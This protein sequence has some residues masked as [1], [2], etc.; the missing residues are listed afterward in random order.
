MHISIE[1]ETQNVIHRTWSPLYAKEE[2]RKNCLPQSSLFQEEYSWRRFHRSYRMKAVSKRARILEQQRWIGCRRKLAR[3]R[4]KV[5]PKQTPLHDRQ[6]RL[7]KSCRTGPEER[8]LEDLNGKRTS[9]E[10][11]VRS[12]TAQNNIDLILFPFGV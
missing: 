1:N 8:R 11:C 6:V 4:E 7:R 5:L 2:Q 3:R 12:K 10:G 9:S